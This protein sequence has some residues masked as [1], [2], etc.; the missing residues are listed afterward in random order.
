MLMQT[1][2]LLFSTWALWQANL[3]ELADARRALLA[4]D[5]HGTESSLKLLP[6]KA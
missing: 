1:M 4:K 2:P 5:K 3:M 6:P